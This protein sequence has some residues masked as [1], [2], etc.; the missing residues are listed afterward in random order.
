MKW[1]VYAIVLSV[2]A[3][4][5][6]A[7]AID[8]VL[9]AY[10]RASRAA[11]LKFLPGMLSNRADNFVLLGPQGYQIDASDERARFRSLLQ[12]ATR[13]KLETR[14]ISCKGTKDELICLVE[15]S[16]QIECVN[17]V[18]HR[19][20]TQLIQTVSRDTWVKTIDG[21]RVAE[22]QVASQIKGAGEPLPRN[23]LRPTRFLGIGGG[24]SEVR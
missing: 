13:V 14:L 17:K 24:R 18:T 10:K 23:Y 11:E 21:W 8:E 22:S 20:D 2:A 5:V 19:L 12:P 9:V 7:K 16:L 3:I 6:K 15:Q 1:I 4:P